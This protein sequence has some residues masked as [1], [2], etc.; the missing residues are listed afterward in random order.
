MLEESARRADENVT[1][2]DSGPL[3]LEILPTDDKPGTEVVVFANSS[4]N[5]KYLVSQ[6]PGRGDHQAPHTV[7]RA[8]LGAEELLQERNE[9]GERLA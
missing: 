9:E 2:G 5:L 1:S 6:L 7:R 4:E 8:P 3:E